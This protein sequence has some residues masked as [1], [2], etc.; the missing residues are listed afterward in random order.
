MKKV[1]YSIIAICTFAFAACTNSSS[2]SLQENGGSGT[3]SI[4]ITEEPTEEL[5]EIEDID[6]TTATTGGI[7]PDTYKAGE[8]ATVSF[9]DIP[10]TVAGFKELQQKLGTT[11]EGAVALQLIAFEMYNQNKTVGEECVKL[12][13]VE[14][15][16]PSVMRRLPDIFKKDDTYGRP[17]LVATYL[18]GATPQNGFNP[19]KPYTIQVRTSAAHPYERCQSL[20]GYI[21]YLEVYSSGYDSHWRGCEVIK[22]KGCDYYKVNNSPSMYVQCMEVPFDADQDYLG[23]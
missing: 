3:D 16:I 4:S 9:S 18:N 20:K 14:N 1:Y 6:I 10:K 19:T 11:P 2:N 12:N 15:N 13:N 7:N 8:T 22:Q 5:N 17:H 21:L 23:L